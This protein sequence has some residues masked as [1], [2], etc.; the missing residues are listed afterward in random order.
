MNCHEFQRQLDDLLDRRQDP[1]R[2]SQ[3][4]AHAADCQACRGRMA[5]WQGIDASLASGRVSLA[6]SEHP[7]NGRRRTAA[8]ATWLGTLAA[9]GLLIAWGHQVLR[10]DPVTGPVAVLPPDATAISPTSPLP[11]RDTD[12]ATSQRRRNADA[13][14]DA[15]VASLLRATPWWAAVQ[16]A[17]VR[18]ENWVR[19]TIPAVVSVRQGVAPIERSMRQ[20]IAILIQSGQPAASKSQ[21]RPEEPSQPFNEQTSKVRRDVRWDDVA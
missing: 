21:M 9:A 18:E 17:A 2:D 8:V 15:G 7:R 6:S 3:L 4:Q 11:S 12:V 1:S 16:E 19:Q 5:I 13:T 10:E 20:A 14:T